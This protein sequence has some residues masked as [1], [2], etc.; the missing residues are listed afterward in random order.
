MFEVGGAAC[1]EALPQGS[2]INGRSAPFALQNVDELSTRAIRLRKPDEFL[3]IVLNNTSK[4]IEKAWSNLTTKESKPK[5]RI[6]GEV[7]L[8]RVFETRG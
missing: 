4:Q 1:L 5:P 6:N 8:L 3:P 2:Q 7:V